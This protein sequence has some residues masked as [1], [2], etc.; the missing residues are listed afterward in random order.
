MKRNTDISLRTPEATSLA[1]TM[2]FNKPV[3]S[4]F[5]DN[6]EQVYEKYHFGPHQI[7]NV[8]ETGLTTVQT[9]SKVLALKGVKQVGQIISGERGQLITVCCC[10]NAIGNSIPPLMVFPR[11]NFKQHMTNGAPPGTVGFA[12]QSEWITS[13]I[14][15]NG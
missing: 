11:V 2:G 8:N 6:L 5:F 10:I 15:W 14:F 9:P 3:V 7:F 1:R 13:D 12:S 4:Q